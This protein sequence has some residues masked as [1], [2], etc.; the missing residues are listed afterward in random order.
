MKF[1]R[2][3]YFAASQSFKNHYRGGNIKWVSSTSF[4]LDVP[5]EHLD[6]WMAGSV[7]ACA[8]SEAEGSAVHPGLIPGDLGGQRPL[9]PLKPSITFLQSVSSLH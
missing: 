1:G 5:F 8:C 3:L 7:A 6:V 9:H 4:L 2:R